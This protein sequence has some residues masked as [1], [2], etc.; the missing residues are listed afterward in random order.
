MTHLLNRTCDSSDESFDTNEI[1]VHD[2]DVVWIA[3]GTLPGA[4]ALAPGQEWF[5]DL[6]VALQRTLSVAEVIDIFSQHVSCLVPHTN[7]D[8]MD[9]DHDTYDIDLGAIAEEQY[10]Y[11]VGLPNEYLGT[12][13]VERS[14]AFS[15]SE[16]AVLEQVI[17]AIVYPL[18]NAQLYRRV[19]NASAVD[20][21]TGL[22]NRAN[23]D[24]TLDRQIAAAHRHGESL[25]MIMLDV[26]Y[27][28]SINDNYGHTAGDQV[29]R[30]LARCIQ[31]CIRD[32]DQAFRYGGEEFAILLNKTDQ[33]G[34]ELLA[35]R[36]RSS[37]AEM[38]VE[39]DQGWVQVTVS[40]GV[41]MWQGESSGLPLLQRADSALYDSKRG[42]RNR[43][44]L[45]PV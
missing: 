14:I 8:F 38:A 42:G 41:S 1:P 39:L 45:S 43:V 25:A 24:Q 18:H 12:L 19:L 29:L 31:G 40:L 32:S 2:V 3:R 37:V 7:I 13:V 20:P 15:D 22:G 17:P 10:T 23:L 5:L 33:L 44:T 4:E 36:I 27:F 6:A 16:V 35:E 21:L 11:R 34:A 30:S 26:D 9:E 28:K